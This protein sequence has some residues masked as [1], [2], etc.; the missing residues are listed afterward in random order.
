MDYKGNY[1][2]HGMEQDPYITGEGW[3]EEDEISTD[4]RFTFDD[5]STII[6]HEDED[7]EVETTR[8]R[9]KPWI[10]D[11]VANLVN[12]EC[13]DIYTAKKYIISNYGHK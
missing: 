2:T 9:R 8:P 7:A 3:D 12:S 11:E 1:M 6:V 10:A 13:W 5:G 4:F